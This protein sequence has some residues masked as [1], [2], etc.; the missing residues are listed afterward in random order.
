MKYE[1]VE[2][3]NKHVSDD[4]LCEDL[5]RVAEILHVRSVSVNQYNEYGNYHSATLSR[6]F[7]SWN[8]ALIKVGLTPEF[9][10]RAFSDEE[11]FENIEKVWVARGKQ[12]VRRDMNSKSLSSISSATYLRRFGTWNAAL[13]AFVDYINSEETESRQISNAQTNNTVRDKRDAN[14]R[15]RFLIMQ[16]DNFKC[17]LC[18]ASPANA[19]SVVLHIDHIIPWSKGGST[20]FDNLRTLCDKCNLGKGDLLPE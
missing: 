20:T 11:L 13:Q 8:D 14:L 5:I 1:F 4:E 16:R 3:H 15:T 19:P 7:G 2:Y 17:C 9:S 12:P 6:R 10:G 18:G